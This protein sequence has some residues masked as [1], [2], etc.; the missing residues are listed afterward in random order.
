MYYAR[1]DSHD[2][3]KFWYYAL[4]CPTSNCVL[5]GQPCK[6]YSF[7]ITP[8]TGRFN[9]TFYKND[10]QWNNASYGTT[11]YVIN[12]ASNKKYYLTQHPSYA[13]AYRTVDTLPYGDY[14]LWVNK[15]TGG[16]VSNGTYTL[17]S[18]SEWYEARYY[19]VTYNGNGNTGGSPPMG[20]TRIY[21]PAQ[22]RK[23]PK[24]QNR[25]IPKKTLAICKRLW[26]NRYVTEVRAVVGS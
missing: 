24:T 26:Y 19:T 17:D 6:L 3:D 5:F 8:S 13:Y 23:I 12:N 11:A 16:F 10:A 20:C 18:A 15:G 7:R 21:L 9:F 2:N 1:N 25:K 4:N 22:N 14:T